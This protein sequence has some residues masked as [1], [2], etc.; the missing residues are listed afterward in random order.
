MCREAKKN[1]A[2]S[3]GWGEVL[4]TTQSAFLQ[5]NRVKHIKYT[6]VVKHNKKIPKMTLK[7]S[8]KESID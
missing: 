7:L 2:G 4:A 3:F 8:Q 6:F 1:L 5:E